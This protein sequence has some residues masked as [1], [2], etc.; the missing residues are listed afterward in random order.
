MILIKNLYLKYIREYY[1]LYDINLNIKEG[2]SVAFIG[3]FESGKTS[4]LR[5]LAK[6]EKFTKGEIY[7]KDIPL[8]K[9]NYATDVHLGYIPSSPVLFGNKTVYDNLKY[10]LKVQKVKK[11]EMERKINDALINFNIES[12]KETKVRDLN[13]FDKYLVSLARLSFRT[14][15]IVLIDDIFNKL[16]EDE[17]EIL[18]QHIKKLYIG[19]STIIIATENEKITKSICK[20][21]VYFKSG[22]ITV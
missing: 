10:I 15:E 6:I 13:L 11:T 18:I 5:I 8:R 14:L 1:A 12:I 21:S 20:K 3:E 22:S 2:E 7:I 17:Q 19:K 9:V 4:L 16:S